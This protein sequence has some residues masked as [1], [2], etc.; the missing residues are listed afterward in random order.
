MNT[1]LNTYNSTYNNKYKNNNNFLDIHE[2]SS[3][4]NTFN[5][6]YKY[7]YSNNNTNFNNNYV[8]NDG[9]VKTERSYNLKK[10]EKNFFENFDFKKNN[11]E[12]EKNLSNLENYIKNE[13]TYNT[14]NFNEN[15][16]I[17]ISI[18]ENDNDKDKNILLTNMHINEKIHREKYIN[19]VIK[20]DLNYGN[21]LN[22][23]NQYEKKDENIN[24]NICNDDKENEDFIFPL[25]TKYNLFSNEM[26]SL[27]KDSDKKN[28]INI[29]PVSSFKL[30]ENVNIYTNFNMNTK[31]NQ[32]INISRRINFNINTNNNNHNSPS[33]N[34]SLTLVLTKN[35]FNLNSSN[36]KF[37]ENGDFN[38][39]LNKNRKFTEKYKN[40]SYL[41]EN[42]VFT[43]KIFSKFENVT[44]KIMDKDNEIASKA[45]SS[46]VILNPLV[47][48]CLK[49]YGKDRKNYNEKK[50]KTLSY[51]L[52]LISEINPNEK[53]DL[54]INFKN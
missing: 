5:S 35:K 27:I 17:Y 25:K 15:K 9:K 54:K 8:I 38:K 13:E 1:N 12:N 28:L 26:K 21:I 39:T 6:D 23:D 33:Y 20:S 45:F 2:N 24:N 51:N 36:F 4:L 41:K 14:V 52:P 34:K 43:P 31:E 42:S 48:N 29:D 37:N 53:K 40:P 32:K 11:K 3:F 22:N 30:N 19:N 44:N 50:Y 46:E 10:F 7:N 16:N 49:I 47:K 18:S